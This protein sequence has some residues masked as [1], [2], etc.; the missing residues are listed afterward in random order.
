MKIMGYTHYH[1]DCPV[2]PQIAADARKIVAASTVSI[3]GPMGTG[4][5]KITDSIIA[6]NGDAST[7]DDYESFVLG[8]TGPVSW[9]CKTDQRPYD[10][11]VVAIL[12]SAM[13]RSEGS[14]RAESDGSLDDW[15]DG[16]DLYERACGPLPAQM[17]SLVS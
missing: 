9:F 16:I 12:I 2:T 14:F 7:D 17:K 11:V 5:P 15:S 10:E 13:L 1:R 8:E 4:K 3:C 6:L